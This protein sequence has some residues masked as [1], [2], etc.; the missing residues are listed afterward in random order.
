MGAQVPACAGM[1][2]GAQRR[3]CS[4]FIFFGVIGG[5][6]GG[7]PIWSGRSA[8]FGFVRICSGLFRFVRGVLAWSAGRRRGGERGMVRHSC[9]GVSVSGVGGSGVFGGWL[10]RAQHPPPISSF[11]RRQEPARP[12]A[13]L[14]AYAGMTGDFPNSS[15]PP[16]RGEVRWGVGGCERPPAIESTIPPPPRASCLRRNDGEGAQE[17]RM[18]GGGMTVGG[19]WLAGVGGW[20]SRRARGLVDNRGVPPPT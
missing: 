9:S 2:V 11:L 16:F 19:A 4:G 20:G 18:G 5:D 8:L 1:T 15:L 10:L 17:W 12:N 13:R 14:P 7:V 6:S 3:R